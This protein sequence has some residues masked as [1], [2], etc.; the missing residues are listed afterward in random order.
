MKVVIQ[1]VL[2][3]SVIINSIVHNRINRGLLIFLGISRDDI[4]EDVNW[5][6]HK[7]S[8]LRIF[9]DQDN[10]MNLSVKDISGEILVISQF[11]L[12]AKVRRGN[13]PSYEDAG[14]PEYAIP[15]Y[16]SFKEHLAKSTGL[17]VKSGIFG[18]DMKIELIN[19][20]PVTIVIDTKSISDDH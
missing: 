12:F 8:N 15:I 19:D 17:E 11:T 7:I 3:A 13:R 18:A 6:T 14:R 16:E 20:G 2:S 1:R 5:L 10:K 9:S 4:P